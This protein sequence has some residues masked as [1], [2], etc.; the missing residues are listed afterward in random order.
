LT[1]ITN[2]A[3]TS[4]A[5]AEMMTFFAPALRCWPALSRVVNRPVDSMTTSTFSSP[6]GSSAG[7][8]SA[9]TLMVL[10]PTVMPS[11]V[12]ATGTSRLPCVES[13]RKRWALTSGDVRSFTA[14]TSM[15]GF[16]SDARKNPRPMRPNPLIA[17]RIA[18]TAP[19]VGGVLSHFGEYRFSQFLHIV[20]HAISRREV[21]YVNGE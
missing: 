10:D 1:P 12:I 19:L 5:G 8:R 3:S 4:V 13:Y 2:V 7:L 16:D 15:S 17:T 11:L 20:D 14:T 6:Q 18:T 21:R 9:S